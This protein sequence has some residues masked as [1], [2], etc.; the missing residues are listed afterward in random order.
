METLPEGTVPLPKAMGLRDVVF[1]FVT[2]GTNLQWVAS[3]AV[4]GPS[5]VT[6]WLIGI[7][8]MFLP[9]ALCVIELSS[10]YP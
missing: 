7:L 9:L 3:A 6:V 4:A 1:F 2:S 5:A 8:V 10:R